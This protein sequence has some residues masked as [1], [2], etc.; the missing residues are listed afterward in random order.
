MST[1]NAR[2]EATRWALTAR[3]DL[4]AAALLTRHA[5]HSLACF[6]C[7]QAAE[8][9]V[10]SLH[11]LYGLDPW[12]HS[13]SKL[14]ADLT[15]VR[16]QVP[17]EVLEAQDDAARL[18]QFYIPTRYPNGVPDITPSQAFRARDASDGLAIAERLVQA[19]E[20]VLGTAGG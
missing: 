14:I 6:H 9:A 11:Y 1:E 10:K 15:P 8:K 12:G 20:R 2:T 4:N 13:V 16:T 7:Q 18:D 19:A 5:M 17:G 3:D